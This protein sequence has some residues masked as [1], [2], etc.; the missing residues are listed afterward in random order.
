MYIMKT[1]HKEYYP[2]W[3]FGIV[4]AVEF[5]FVVA[6]IIGYAIFFTPFMA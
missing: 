2:N 5:L 1:D 3:V 6:F 4:F